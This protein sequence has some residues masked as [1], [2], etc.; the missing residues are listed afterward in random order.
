MSFKKDVRLQVFIT[1]KMDDKLDDMVSLMGMHK[2]EIIRVA[3]AN[4][5]YT[6]GESV[7]LARDLATSGDTS[8][9]DLFK[10]LKNVDEPF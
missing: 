3:I 8:V 7:N 2:N 1:S 4:Y 5:L 10:R 6:W 9:F